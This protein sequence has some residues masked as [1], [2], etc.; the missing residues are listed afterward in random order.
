MNFL[1]LINEMRIKTD[2]DEVSS[3]NSN[4]RHL[5]RNKINVNRAYEIVWNSL[6]PINEAAEAQTTVTTTQGQ[7][8][9]AAPYPQ[10]SSIQ[11]EGY[12]P[13]VILPWHEWEI[14]VREHCVHYQSY[15]EAE[16]YICSVYG[17]NIYFYPTPDQAYTL[18]VRGNSRFTKLVNDTD[19]PGLDAGYHSVISMMA[20]A[21]ELED[22]GDPQAQ[23]KKADALTYLQQVRKNQRGHQQ[24]PHQVKTMEELMP[25][26]E[27]GW[28]DCL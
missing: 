16:P 26:W 3:V 17:G 7:E 15:E 25:I 1:E 22:D 11:R 4:D 19:T 2:L 6:Y 8:T 12:T 20:E 23:L 10:I 5:A 21:M 27:W 28:T 18:R 13:Y 24:V 14:R 9:V